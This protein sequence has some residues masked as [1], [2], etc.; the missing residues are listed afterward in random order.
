MDGEALGAARAIGR[1]LDGA[2]LGFT[3]LAAAIPAPSIAQGV[4]TFTP[5]TPVR[6]PAA[7]V[8]EFHAY[9][10]RRAYTSRQE[11]QHRARVAFC[12]SRSWRLTPRE[13]GFLDGIAR[14]HGNLTFR[15]GDCLAALTDRLVW[16]DRRAC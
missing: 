6:T 9:R 13:R 5:K 4:K 2:G 14:Q 12:Q 8:P 11:Q 7:T 15:Q 10:L 16:E 3:D 1:V